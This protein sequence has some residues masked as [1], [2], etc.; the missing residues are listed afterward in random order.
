MTSSG[1]GS[2]SSS[3]HLFSLVR[4]PLAASG[5]EESISARFLDIS[6]DQLI[7]IGANVL[8]VFRIRPQNLTDTGENKMEPFHNKQDETFSPW[9]L[10]GFRHADDVWEW[11]IEVDTDQ[12]QS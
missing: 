6:E 8:K 9:Y 3:S 2:S 10:D 5:I 1:G 4:T 11:L 7:T 12:D